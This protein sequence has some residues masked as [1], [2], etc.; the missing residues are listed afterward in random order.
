MACG[1]VKSNGVPF[2]ALISP[3]VIKRSINRGKMIGVYLQ[4]VVQNSVISVAG[5]VKIAMVS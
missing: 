4:A 2:T 3:V 1:V 5:K